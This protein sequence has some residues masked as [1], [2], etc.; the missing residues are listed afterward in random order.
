MTERSYSRRSVAIGG[1]IAVALGLTAL[2]VSLPKLLGHRYRPTPYDDLL[3]RLVDR[4]AAAK[5]GKVA[6]D[7]QAAMSGGGDFTPKAPAIARELRKRMER[8]TLAEVTRSDLA[9]GSLHEVKGWVLPD[10][11]VRLSMLASLES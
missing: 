1:G 4:D 11:L 2:G 10:T 7:E 3:A 9:Q 6:C 5:L 8:R